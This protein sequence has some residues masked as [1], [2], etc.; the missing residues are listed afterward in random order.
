MNNKEFILK[1]LITLQLTAEVPKSTPHYFQF[2]YSNRIFIFPIVLLIYSIAAW[3][4]GND[5]RKT[6]IKK[7][8]YS[9]FVFAYLFF[10]RYEDVSTWCESGPMGITAPVWSYLLSILVT[11]LIAIAIDNFIISGYVFKEFGIFGAKFIRDATQ[12]TVIQQNGYMLSLEKNLEALYSVLFKINELFSNPNIVGQV[13]N[14]R[15]NFSKHFR[16]ILKHYYDFKDE[17]VKIDVQFFRQDADNIKNIIEGYNIKYNLG[18]KD[19][20]DLKNCLSNNDG[21]NW[22]LDSKE[23]KVYV[24][25]TKVKHN[26]SNQLLLISIKSL[27]EIN[28]YDMY[29]VLN[30]LHVF[31]LEFSKI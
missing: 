30:F 15:F 24:I 12:Q 18:F 7:I 25:T 14:G 20:R 10:I 16:G 4:F 23:Y 8:H 13:R 28:I 2:L 26:N 5:E 31:E 11:L 3:K 19:K 27:D 22:Y 17:N 9:L 21:A 29:P 6:N 1:H